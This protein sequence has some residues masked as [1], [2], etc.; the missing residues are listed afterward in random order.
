MKTARLL[1]DTTWRGGAWGLL[2]GTL[3]GTAYGAIFANVLLFLGLLS[4]DA[5]QFQ[6]DDVPRAMF[7]MLVLALIGAVMGALFGVPTGFV[8]GLFNGLLIG[9]VTRIFF[10]PLRDAAKHR[11]A[12][13]IVSAI[14]TILASWF[15]FFSIMLFYANRAQAS[16]PVLALVGVIPALIAGAAGWFVARQIARWY[17]GV[18]NWKSDV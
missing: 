17:A 14:F 9:L 15:C 13:G 8:V 16:V 12:V 4:Q 10:F 2:S 11:R 18:G 3:L 5:A 7:A 1:F 6:L